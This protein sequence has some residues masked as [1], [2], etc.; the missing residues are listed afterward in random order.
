MKKKT[1]V[2]EGGEKEKF[3]SQIF[4]DRKEKAE[5]HSGSVR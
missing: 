1:G 2:G 5:L 3:F 4:P